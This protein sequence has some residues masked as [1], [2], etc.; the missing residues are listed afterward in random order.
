MQGAH[1]VSIVPSPCGQAPVL[2]KCR[3]IRRLVIIWLSKA[4]VG[5][6]NRLNNLAVGVSFDLIETSEG[7]WQIP[8]LTS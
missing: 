6:Y 8:T 7:T 5:G 2:D 1:A 4:P 3:R